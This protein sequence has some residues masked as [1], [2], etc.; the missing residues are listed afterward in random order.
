MA[1]ALRAAVRASQRA[2]RQRCGAAAT[3][4]SG[5]SFATFAAFAPRGSRVAFTPQMHLNAA[6]WHNFHAAAQRDSAAARGLEQWGSVTPPSAKGRPLR[7]ARQPAQRSL[8]VA[9]CRRCV[10]RA[11]MSAPLRSLARLRGCLRARPLRGEAACASASPARPCR[12]AA[13][14]PPAPPPRLPQGAAPQLHAAR[15]CGA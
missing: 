2:Q 7:R 3:L 9:A 13:L 14:L 4:S 12:A 6:A 11:A 15:P 8:P 10:L 5:P 1:C